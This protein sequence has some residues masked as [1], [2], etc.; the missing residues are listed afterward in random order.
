[1]EVVTAFFHTLLSS[2][3]QKHLLILFLLIQVLT[4][5]FELTEYNGDKNGRDFYETVVTSIHWFYFDIQ[6]FL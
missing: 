1:M 2:F 5:F 4:C 6:H 3:R